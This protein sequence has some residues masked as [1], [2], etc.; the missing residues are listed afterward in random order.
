M[1]VDKRTGQALADAKA[2]TDF[3]VNMSHVIRTPMSGQKAIG[4][5]GLKSHDLIFMGCQMP[6]MDGFETT[7]AVRAQE[8]EGGLK[9]ISDSYID[10]QCCGRRKKA[11]FRFWH[12]RLYV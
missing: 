8:Q 11:V 7:V 9:Q 10:C 2:N 1:R 5:F 6:G 3:L 12:G 4:K